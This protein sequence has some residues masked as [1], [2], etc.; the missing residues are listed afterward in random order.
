MALADWLV[1]SYFAPLTKSLFL[2]NVPVK[3]LRLDYYYVASSFIVAFI[4][5]DQIVLWIL[6][7]G[8]KLDDTNIIN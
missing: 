1:C 4:I 8:I 6:F 2:E 5:M 3:L 7:I